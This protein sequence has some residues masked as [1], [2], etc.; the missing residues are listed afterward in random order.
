[1]CYT[2]AMDDAKKQAPKQLQ[3]YVWKK[4]QSGNSR[5]RPKKIASFK[6]D[7]AAVLQE[8]TV[9]GRRVAMG[10]QHAF[11]YDLHLHMRFDQVAAAA[12]I[13]RHFRRDVTHTS[14]EHVVS[15]HA[16]EAGGVLDEARAEAVV[17]GQDLVFACL[18][19]PQSY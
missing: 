12:H 8:K 15:A 1:M 7:L 18:L 3:P 5:G 2:L 10:D 6:S 16:L 9:A 17:E 14:V 13:G 11:G 19:P 4:G